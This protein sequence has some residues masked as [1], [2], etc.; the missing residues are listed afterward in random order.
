MSSSESITPVQVLRKSNRI[1]KQALPISGKIPRLGISQ[2]LLGEPVRYDGGHKRDPFLTDTLS[3]FVEWVPI[4]PEVESGLG[5]PREA[6]RLV[7]TPEAPRLM[8][9]KTQND[10]TA[11]LNRFCHRKIHELKSL[12]LDGFVFKKDSP[13]CGIKQV[14]VYQHGSSPSRK[15]RGLFAKAFQ[16]FFPLIPIEDEERL[17]DTGVRQNF[18]ERLF[19]YH[20]WQNLL[21]SGMTR[22]GIVTFHTQHKYFLMAHSRPQY[23]KLGHLVASAK[24]YTPKQLALQYGAIFMEALK[25]KTTVRKHL[26]VLQH[27]VGHFKQNI[28]QA[29]RLELQEGISDYHRGLT[30]LIAPLNLINHYVREYH[31]DNLAE[32]IYLQPHPKELILRYYG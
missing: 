18:I 19:A 2:C 8:T 28:T 11:P 5:T 12:R 7:G 22:G 4:C 16:T 25:V 26:N 9:I 17:N 27:L 21:S 23:H 31:I 14:R 20:R 32:Q 30:P 29:Q 3:Q 13:S 15:G 10:H 6:M 1:K 24:H